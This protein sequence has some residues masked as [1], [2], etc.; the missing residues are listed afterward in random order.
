[1]SH[2]AILASA[3]L[4]VSHAGHAEAKPAD[5]VFRCRMDL[6]EGA[7]PESGEYTFQT[8]GKTAG[9]ESRAAMDYSSGI[10]ARAAVYPTDAKDLLNPYSNLSLTLGFVM[11]GD[12]KSSPRE[13]VVSFGAIGKDFQVISGA[14]ITLK[15]VIDGKVFGPY[16]P[17]PV[18]SGM[19]L[20]WL[21][22]AD[23]DGDSKPP[24]LPPADF[25]KLATAVI[26]MKT[27]EIV[28]VR[29][30]EDLVTGSIP[31]PQL[32]TWRD[33]LPPWAAKASPAVSTTTYCTAG[34]QIINRAALLFASLD[35]PQQRRFAPAQPGACGCTLLGLQTVSVL[36]SN[37]EACLIADRRTTRL[38]R[39][40]A[41]EG[42]PAARRL[43]TELHQ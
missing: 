5:W 22:T 17:K 31:L 28:L 7:K 26:K 8:R 21:D 34:G 24:L 41:F 39:E 10:S 13:G 12:G 30:G 37:S 23:T 18:S 43:V 36:A 11:P 3:A 32:G 4:L 14:P 20:V 35:Q 9:A 2:F 16:E 33:G 38:E 29:E 40:P 42:S 1:M 27:A 19:Y 25:A 15:L 6:A